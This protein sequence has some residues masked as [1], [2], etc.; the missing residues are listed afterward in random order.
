MTAPE[1]IPHQF[2]SKTE[3][4]PPDPSSGFPGKQEV[5]ISATCVPANGEEEVTKEFTNYTATVDAATDAEYAT[6]L[7]N[8]LKGSIYVS[9]G[10]ADPDQL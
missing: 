1:S 3:A 10:Y 4:F 8:A 6:A 5:T 7:Y 9:F 2:V